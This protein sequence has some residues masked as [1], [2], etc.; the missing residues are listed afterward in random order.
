[1]LK[2]M[3]NITLTGNSMIDDQQVV[4][5][6]ASISTEGER[7]NSSSAIQNRELYN[8]NKAQCRA[9]IAA[10]DQM[11]YEIEDSITVEQEVTE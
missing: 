11:V 9:D 6:N 8:A 3:K 2:T 7:T 4:Y 5:M 10:F 1:M